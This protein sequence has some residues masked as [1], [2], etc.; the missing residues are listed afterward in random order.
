MKIKKEEGWAWHWHSRRPSFFGI[1]L[2]VVGMLWLAK[3]MG[4]ITNVPIW[5]VVMIMLG[6]YFVL[7]RSWL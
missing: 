2:I 5:P 4:W 3:E 7:K 6:A 1:F